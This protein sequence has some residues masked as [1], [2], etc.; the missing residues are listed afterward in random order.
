MN[1]SLVFKEKIR[2]SETVEEK[3]KT[4]FSAKCKKTFFTEPVTSALESNKIL[5]RGAVRQIIIII[6]A[7][8]GHDPA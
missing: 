5:D 4:T 7:A 6:V 8:L 1:L 2:E 3:N